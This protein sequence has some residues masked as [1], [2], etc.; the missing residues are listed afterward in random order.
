MDFIDSVIEGGEEEL[1]QLAAQLEPLLKRRAAVE[2]IVRQA[3]MVKAGAEVGPPDPMGPGTL[4]HAPTLPSPT[5]SLWEG[6]RDVLTRQDS[7]MT[8]PQ[9]ASVMRTEG[10]KLTKN[11]PEVVRAAMLR[12]NDVFKALGKGYYA[13]THWKVASDQQE[14]TV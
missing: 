4:F 5:K 3:K 7:P 10:Y 13:L 14:A 9:I 6:A 2:D 8:A 11:G 12:R 1:R